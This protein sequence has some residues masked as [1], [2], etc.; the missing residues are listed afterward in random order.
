MSR[1]QY[2]AILRQKGVLAQPEEEAPAELQPAEPFAESAQLE[3]PE[4]PTEEDKP[5]LA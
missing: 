5:D 2:I 1:V 3:A 4:E